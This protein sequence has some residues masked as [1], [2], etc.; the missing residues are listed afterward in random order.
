V[1]ERSVTVEIDGD[2]ESAGEE[3]LIV[4]AGK[5]SSC[6]EGEGASSGVAAQ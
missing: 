2:L 4:T 5:P 3:L 6:P 1:T